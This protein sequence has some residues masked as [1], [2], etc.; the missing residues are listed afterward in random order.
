MPTV[1]KQIGGQK[2]P[3]TA[4]RNGLASAWDMVDSIRMLLYGESGTGKT[5][6]WA[7]FPGPISAAICSGGRKPGELRSIDTPE[8]RKKISPFIINSTADFETW[9]KDAEKAATV[10]VDHASGFADLVLKELLGLDEIPIGKYKI[11]G[12]GESWGIASQQ[13]FGQQSLKC[14]EYFRAL[15]NLPGNVVIVAQERLFKGAEEGISDIIKPSIGAAMTPSLVGWLNPACDFVVQSYKRPKMTA[16]KTKVGN[17]EITVQ[18]RGKGVEYCIRTEPHDIFMTK[19][20]LLKGRML[21]ECIV[22]PTYSKILKLIQGKKYRR[23]TGGG[24]QR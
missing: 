5:T 7:T 16:V 19:F 22:D 2:K 21:P 8:Y 23:G 13:Q 6:F 3:V 24:L 20:R 11:A 4:S 14:K 15:L 9:L 17:Q 1:T 12:K 10:V 18:Q